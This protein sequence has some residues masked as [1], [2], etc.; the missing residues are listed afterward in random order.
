MK[1]RLGF[2]R[3]VITLLLAISY[4]GAPTSCARTDDDRE[5]G[6]AD[7]LL[8]DQ[9]PNDKGIE[10]DPHVRFAELFDGDLE[11]IFARYTDVKNAAD[12]SLEADAPAGS[13]IGK[14]ICI[15]NN[16]GTTDGGHLYKRFA[17]GIDDTVFLR[18]YVK[19]PQASRNNFHHVSVRIGGYDPP[20]DWPYGT[21]GI[22]DLPTRF[23]VSYEP[24]TGQDG[25]METYIYWPE[26]RASNAAGDQCYGNYLINNAG[27][28][29][30]AYD[31][32][33]CVELMVKLNTPGK[34]DGE[35]R[36]WH[37][38]QE[39]GHWKPG[40]PRGSWNRDRF[41]HAADG[42]PFEGFMWR[43]AAHPGLNVNNVKFEFY[44]TKSPEGHHNYVQY[45]HLVIATKRIGPIRH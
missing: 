1:K 28:K 29:S 16:G 13:H 9:Y 19:Y 10:T 33:I 6:V 3:S 5:N 25:E 35:L 8:A 27:R 15:T 12:M 37:D 45:S 42:D 41:T 14:S 43:D 32:W 40:S 34:H 4:M 23:N 11:E 30:V 7:S 22:C 17:P 39:M 38:G 18:Y 31:Q 36:V 21:A 20:S 44:D 24:I 2:L 26:M